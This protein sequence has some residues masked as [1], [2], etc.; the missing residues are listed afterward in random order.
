MYTAESLQEPGTV[1]C[2]TRTGSY[3]VKGFLNRW[4]CLILKIEDAERSALLRPRNTEVWTVADMP[5]QPY[6][7]V[8]YRTVGTFTLVATRDGLPI[9][10]RERGRVDWIHNR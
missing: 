7:P 8:E 9:V 5:S 4:Y 3:W 2:S 6:A 1:V 10:H